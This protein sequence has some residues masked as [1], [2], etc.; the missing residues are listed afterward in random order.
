MLLKETVSQRVDEAVLRIKPPSRLAINDTEPSTI[1]RK[2]V[3]MVSEDID[4]TDSSSTYPNTEIKETFGTRDSCGG[5][6]V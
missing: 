3:S 5:D 4:P 2:E 6:N 1:Q